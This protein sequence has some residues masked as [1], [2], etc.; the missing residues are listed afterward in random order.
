M[1]GRKKEVR[2]WGSSALRGSMPR[3]DG[4]NQD[5]AP[6]RF[7]QQRSLDFWIAIHS[8]KRLVRRF[9]FPTFLTPKFRIWIASRNS[10]WI[11]TETSTLNTPNAGERDWK[12]TLRSLLLAKNRVA[13]WPWERSVLTCQRHACVLLGINTQLKTLIH[14]F[15]KS[16]TN[17][18]SH[19]SQSHNPHHQQNVL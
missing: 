18:S 16:P 1:E 9:D 13:R 14:I 17:H 11:T 3:P 12:P 4:S 8:A 5:L 15:T 7:Q 6:A 2:A 10:G 19:T